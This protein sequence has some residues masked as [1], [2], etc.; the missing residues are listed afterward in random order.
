VAVLPQSDSVADID[1]GLRRIAKTRR[2]TE[3]IIADAL[4]L[5]AGLE[6]DEDNLLDARSQAV[7][8][9]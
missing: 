1:G 4:T 6:I 9:G 5:L 8:S 2:T 7:A 3:A